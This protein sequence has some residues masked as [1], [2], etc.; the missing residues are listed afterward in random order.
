MASALFL[1]P[2]L[3]A[4]GL[5]WD[6]AL[7]PQP[8]GT[9]IQVSWGLCNHRGP[10]TSKPPTKDALICSKR[11]LVS[12]LSY[13]VIHPTF[14]PCAAPMLQGCTCRVEENPNASDALPT[15][16]ASTS[17][18]R[19]IAMHCYCVLLEVF[20]DIEVCKYPGYFGVFPTRISKTKCRN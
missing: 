18:N 4:P 14:P 9:H 8:L 6:K 13:A 12:R 16:T 7:P 19:H 17:S 20:K 10:T 3:S 2:S 5:P 1:S 11:R 15:D